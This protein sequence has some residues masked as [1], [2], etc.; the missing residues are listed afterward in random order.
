MRQSSAQSSWRIAQALLVAADEVIGITKPACLGHLGNVERRVGEQSTRPLQPGV[1]QMILKGARAEFAE[2]TGNMI[3]VD[4]QKVRHLLPPYGM[5]EVLFQKLAG[6]QPCEARLAPANHGAF[7]QRGDLGGLQQQQ[8]H[9]AASYEVVGCGVFSVLE[10]LEE[11]PPVLIKQGAVMPGMEKAVPT[12]G[13]LGQQQACHGRSEDEAHGQIAGGAV[14]LHQREWCRHDGFASREG[15]HLAPMLTQHRVAPFTGQTQGKAR[16]VMHRQASPQR[17]I[18][19][20]QS[21]MH[22]SRPAALHLA[23]D[24]GVPGRSGGG[25]HVT[26]VRSL[27]ARS[28]GMLRKCPPHWDI[29]FTV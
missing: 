23:M 13:L 5:V 7:R 27:L 10:S 25:G 28:S 6:G 17:G 26:I 9:K 19:G 4:V 24:P 2:Q 14:R 20:F 18:T 11:M 3:G 29:F 16:A 8:F 15:D 22:T 21:Q 1:H 12:C